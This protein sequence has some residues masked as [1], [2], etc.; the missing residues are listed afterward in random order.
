MLHSKLGASSASRWMNCPGSVNMINKCDIKS[1]T[2][3]YAEEGTAAHEL[4]EHCLLGDTNPHDHLGAEF[5]GFKVTEEMADAVKVYV[6]FVRRTADG[7]ELQVERQFKLD[8]IHPVM[9]GTNDACAGEPFGT[10]HVFDY[11]HGAGV[12]VNVEDNS[13]LKYYALGAAHGEDYERV[14][15]HIIQPRAYHPDGPV[16]SW[17]LSIADLNKYAEELK[18]AAYAT[19]KPDAP[20]KAGSHCR[21]CPVI[22]V[23]PEMHKTT[24]EV[25]KTDFASPMPEINELTDDQLAK[26]LKYED[27]IKKFIDEAKARAFQR[28]QMGVKL[29]GLKIVRKRSSRKWKDET[30]VAEKLSETFDEELIYNKKIKTVAQM[31]KVIEK[32]IVKQYSETKEGDLTVALQ[33]DRR[34]E[35]KLSAIDDFSEAP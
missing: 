34:K 24:I 7:L 30:M 8:W 25:A 1:E 29:D 33:N 5:N 3:I 13:Q 28:M 22:G 2:S 26:V 12:A 17:G 4:G 27:V 15:L 11:K 31:E 10:L 18:V 20:I 6:D 19:E 23:C 14:E 32:D 21:W 16:R 35:V 9:F